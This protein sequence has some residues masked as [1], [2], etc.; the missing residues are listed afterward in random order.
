MADVSLAYLLNVFDRETSTYLAANSYMI[1]QLGGRLSILAQ[2][3]LLRSMLSSAFQSARALPDAVFRCST[4][5]RTVILTQISAD[6][7]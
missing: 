3:G 7:S 5:R 4:F 1:P 2:L 6:P